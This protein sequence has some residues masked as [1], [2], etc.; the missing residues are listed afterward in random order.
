MGTVT[1]LRMVPRYDS[2]PIREPEAEKPPVL[3]SL[4]A[5]SKPF[6]VPEMSIP[7]WAKAV[8]VA[9]P[10]KDDCDLQSDYYNVRGGKP[11]LLK[12]SKH[13]RDLFP[14]MRRAARKHPQTA[15][16]ERG[17]DRIE[18]REKWSMGAGYYLKAGSRY[19]TG[20]KVQKMRLDWHRKEVELALYEGRTVI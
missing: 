13:T 16:L 18:H 8:I 12:W 6:D 9:I 4:L 2:E 5:A 10:E 14:E 15:H 20:W 3:A 17:G 19:D 1:Y 7:E 11:I